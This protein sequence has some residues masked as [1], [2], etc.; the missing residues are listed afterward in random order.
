MA[1]PVSSLRIAARDLD[2]VRRHAREGAPLEICGALVGRREENDVISVEQ[3]V[4][5]RNAHP[6]PVKEYLLDA[7]ELMRVVLRAE[8]EWGLEVV[9]FYHSHPAGP[10]RLSATD[11]ARASWPGAAYLLCWLAPEEGVGC[12]TWDADAKTFHPRTLDIK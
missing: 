7:E 2:D 6:N 9:G 1:Q 3:V 4:R 8:D 11:H 10:P 5:M 12:W